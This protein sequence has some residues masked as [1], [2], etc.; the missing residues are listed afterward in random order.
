[1]VDW[2]DEFKPSAKPE[3]PKEKVLAGE[4]EDMDEQIPEERVIDGLGV[5]PG[6]AIGNAQVRESGAVNVPEY[7]IATTKVTAEQTR[8]RDAVARARRQ[9]AR[10]RIKA[11]RRTN[12]LPN[13]ASDELGYLLDAYFHMLKDSRLVRG[14]TQRIAS[15]RINA[16]AAV[17]AEIAVIA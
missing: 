9:I 8:L 11:R 16:E 3:K 1:M 5:S 6:I 12:N 14:A 15:E 2:G 13:A 7:R 10:L 4:R 17:Q